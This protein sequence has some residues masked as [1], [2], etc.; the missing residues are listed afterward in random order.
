M[1]NKYQKIFIV[2][3]LISMQFI[4]GVFVLA[5]EKTVSVKK[6]IL[7]NVPFTSQA[8]YGEWKDKRQQDGCEEASALM[9]VYWAR[10]KKLTKEIA[11]KEI[12][13]IADYE[14]KKYGSYV[15]TSAST[16]VE[17][18]FN[19]YFKFENVEVVYDIKLEDIIKE[20]EA[21]NVVIIP[22]NGRKL[23]NSNFTA[24]GPDRHNVLIRGYDYK[25]K[26]FI[27]NDAGTRRGEKYRYKEKVLFKAI[28]DYSTGDH[29]P[30]KGEKKVMIVVKK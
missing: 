16:T 2:I 15:D 23:G 1:F 21:G 26:E 11:K 7:L 28:R 22:A 13:A 12:L 27:T 10:G 29:A 6:T 19:D 20:L 5:A 30:I 17:R 3:F 4:F 25:T 24:P 9:A 14:K 8:P 18:I